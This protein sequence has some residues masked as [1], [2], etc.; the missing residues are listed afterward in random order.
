[1]FRRRRRRGLIKKKF[2]KKSLNF[3][4]RWLRRRKPAG[5][6]VGIPFHLLLRFPNLE[7]RES[8]FVF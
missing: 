4:T 2:K 6:R 1:V 5:R 8:K 7:R 3:P